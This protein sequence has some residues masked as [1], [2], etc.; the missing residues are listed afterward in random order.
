MSQR[1]CGGHAQNSEA[2]QAHDERTKELSEIKLRLEVDAVFRAR[3]DFSSAHRLARIR[4]LAPT[5]PPSSCCFAVCTSSRELPMICPSVAGEG[6]QVQEPTGLAR[7]PG[8][9][10]ARVWGFLAFA[11]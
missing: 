3:L 4:T 6:Q 10:H 5:L 11:V 2:T 1:L 9:P 8:A 7:S